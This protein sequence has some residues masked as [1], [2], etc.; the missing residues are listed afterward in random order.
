V[1]RSASVQCDPRVVTGARGRGGAGWGD[2]NGCRKSMSPLT[3]RRDCSHSF[4]SPG[5]AAAA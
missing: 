5:P 3:C 1:K 2:D 4:H